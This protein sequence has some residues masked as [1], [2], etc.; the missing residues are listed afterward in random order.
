MSCRRGAVADRR[1]QRP[2]R[3][4]NP[5][6]RRLPTTGF[7]QIRRPRAA[8]TSRRP[9]DSCVVAGRL[10]SCCFIGAV[11]VTTCCDP[12]ERTLQRPRLSTGDRRTGGTRHEVL[13]ETLLVAVASDCSARS[14][15]VGHRAAANAGAEHLP[16]RRPIRLRCTARAR[17]ARRSLRSASRSRPSRGSPRIHPST[18][19]FRIAGGTPTRVVQRLRHVS[20]WP[21]SRWHW[22]CWPAR[23]SRSD[24][25]RVIRPPGFRRTH[26][27][28]RELP[29]R[30]S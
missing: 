9:R 30:I 26:P 22:C 24:P 13:A 5:A 20:W 14:G 3:A 7:A 23:A 27:T 25:Q 8:S 4:S 16:A 19:L 29:T 11:N 17:R 6:R 2:S 18:A 10:C 12:L 28:A 1:A 21:I 15:R